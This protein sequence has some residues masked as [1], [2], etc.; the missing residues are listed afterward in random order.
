MGVDERK[1]RACGMRSC[2]VSS[3]GQRLQLLLKPLLIH[4][5]RD[6]Q[7]GQPGQS[8]LTAWC[9]I[10]PQCRIGIWRE[11]GGGAN[12]SLVPQPTLSFAKRA[13]VWVVTLDIATGYSPSVGV[14]CPPL[15]AS[16]VV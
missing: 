15:S 3:V 11:Q 9:L 10:G 14:C 7:H 1:Q 2:D 5:E 6:V 16:A 12:S 8:C 4:I 13:R